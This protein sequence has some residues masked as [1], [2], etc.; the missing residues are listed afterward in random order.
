MLHSQDLALIFLYYLKHEDPKSFIRFYNEWKEEDHPRDEEGKFSDK[1]KIQTKDSENIKELR[2]QVKE[3]LLNITRKQN[4]NHPKLGKIRISLKSVKEFIAHGWAKE[5]LCLAYHL[6]DILE[7]GDI[8][9]KEELKHPRKD[10]I[11]C[12]ILLK[13]QIKINKDYKYIRSFISVDKNGNMFYDLFINEP[14]ELS[15][16]K[17]KSGSNP[18]DSKNNLH[19]TNNSVNQVLNLFIED[20]YTEII[21]FNF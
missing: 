18:A 1:I 5:K 16:P 4:I 6:K 7:K 10:G 8:E 20:I 3:H 13:T 2:D 9:G 11:K 21:D 15:N 14:A 19:Q 12:F 17:Q